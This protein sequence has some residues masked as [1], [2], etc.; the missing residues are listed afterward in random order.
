MTIEQVREA[1]PPVTDAVRRFAHE[2]VRPTAEARDAARRWEPGLFAALAGTGL[3]GALVPASL[4]GGG[5]GATEVAGALAALGAG[6]RVVG[7]G[8]AALGHAVLATAPVR[9]FGTPEQRARLLPDLA[10]GSR[11]GA[12]SLRE[13]R[14]WAAE[15]GVRATATGPGWV[16]TGALDLVPQAASADH[17]VVVAGHGDGTRT[18]FLLERGATGLSVDAAAPLAVPTGGWGG[19]VLDGVPVGADA[20]LGGVGRAGTGVEP[21]LASLD[22]TFTSALWVGVMRALTADAPARM[23]AR[24]L[25]GRPVSHVQSAR[26]SLADMAARCELAWG[27]VERAARAFDDG[28]PSHLH[29]ATARHFTSAAARFTV[30]RAA[31]LCGATGTARERTAERAHR[32][33]LFLA[34]TGGVEVLRPVIAASV[35]GL[36]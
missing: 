34:D 36:G 16:L 14:G 35:L 7:F 33:A 1:A 28:E 30:D 8:L 24:T 27:L 11:I 10:S 20:V 21:L 13:T 26:L 25:F 3:T 31:E 6:G 12:V 22:W 15:P 9:A 18:A 19:V 4:G 2:R 5:R 17:L 29:A 32:D 23:G